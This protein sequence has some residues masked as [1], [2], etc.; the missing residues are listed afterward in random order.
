M[1]LYIFTYKFVHIQIHTAV[2]TD[3]MYTDKHAYVYTHIHMCTHTHTNKYIDTI[4]RQ[5]NITDT[6]NL[7]GKHHNI[8]SDHL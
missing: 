7:G 4:D 6:Q 1:Y 5:K 3:N 2:I 8:N